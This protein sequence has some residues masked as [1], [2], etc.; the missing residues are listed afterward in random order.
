MIKNLKSICR[1]NQYTETIIYLLKEQ[2][3]KSFWVWIS[4]FIIWKTAL[5]LHIKALQDSLSSYKNHCTSLDLF[6]S[7]F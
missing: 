7:P 5:L 2:E 1:I 3:F 4:G 6:S